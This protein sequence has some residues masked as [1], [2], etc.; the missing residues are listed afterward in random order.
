MEIIDIERLLRYH[1]TGEVVE[2]RMVMRYVMGAGFILF[3]LSNYDI[4]YLISQN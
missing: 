3:F 2:L 4:S 1:T